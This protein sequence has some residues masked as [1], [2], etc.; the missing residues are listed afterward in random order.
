MPKDSLFFL[1]YE[2]VFLQRFQRFEEHDYE[3]LNY[4]Y[5]RARLVV[6]F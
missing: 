2:K 1:G 4:P 6:T 3:I 5:F